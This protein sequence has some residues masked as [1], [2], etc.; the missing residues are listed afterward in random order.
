MPVSVKT[1][2]GYAKNEIDTWIPAFLKEDIAALTVHLR[3][4]NEMSDVAAHWKL[5]PKIVA[6]RDKYAPNT[7]ILCNGDV[8]SFA[9]WPRK[10]SLPQASTASWSAAAF[11]EIP[12]FFQKKL[13]TSKK[14]WTRMVIHAKLFEKLYA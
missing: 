3:T 7:I 11:L 12:G 1:R 10:R 8:A 6:L 9:G 14:N 2:I 4:R 13:L 5:A